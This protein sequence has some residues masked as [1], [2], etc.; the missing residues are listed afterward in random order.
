PGMDAASIRPVIQD[1]AA[2]TAAWY[3]KTGAYPVNHLLCLRTELAQAHPWLPEELMRLFQAA[4]AAA[5]EPSAEA[6]FA[7]IVGADVLPYGLAANRA[8]IELCLRYA[9]EQGLLPRPTDVA[10]LFG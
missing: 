8:G 4:K 9:A 3:R 5:T 1:A 7:P 6:R 10:A 2:A